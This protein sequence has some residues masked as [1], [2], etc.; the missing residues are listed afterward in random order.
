[1]RVLLIT[2]AG[3]VLFSGLAQ[4]GPPLLTSDTGTPGDGHWEINVGLSLERTLSQTKVAVP[5]LDFNYGLGEK[6][7]LKYEVPWIFSNPD[8]DEAKNGIGNSALGLKWRFLDEDR[9]G[10][11]MSVYPQVEFNTASSS[12]DKG[13]VDKGTKF[14]LPIEI[15]RK[16][17]AVNVTGELG[18]IFDPEN[19]NQWIYGLAFGYQISKDFEWVG[20]IFGGASSNLE[21]AT[22]DLVFNLGFRWK[23]N[24]WLSLNTSAGRSLHSVTGNEKMLLFYTGLQFAF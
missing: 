2:L 18:Y 5:L 11:A 14:I 19:E 23:L 6:I 22:N 17:G 12:V 16:I 21:W 9:L 24:Q 13:V 4:A 7:Q 15:E 10:I 3:L 20:E 8:G 1:V